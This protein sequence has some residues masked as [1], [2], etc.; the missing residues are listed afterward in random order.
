MTANVFT[1]ILS[2][3]VSRFREHTGKSTTTD[4]TDAN[5]EKWINDYYQNHFPEDADVDLL[6]GWHTQETSAVDDGEYSLI[7]TI[8]KLKKPVFLGRGGTETEIEL[9]QNR[10]LFFRMFPENEQYVTAPSLAIGSNDTTRLANSAFKYDIQGWTYTKAAAETA[11]SG[12]STVPQNK[13]GA[14]SLKIDSDGTVTIAEATDNS[15]G[16]ETAAK[17]INDLSKADSDSAYMGFVTVI[18]TDSGGFIPGTTALDDSAITDTYTD[19]QPGNRQAPQAVCVY[20]SYLY[21][22]P[23]PDDIYQIR[24]PKLLRP[25]ALDS[26]EAPLDIKWGSAIATG[27]ALLY[28][29]SVMKDEDRAAELKPLFDYFIEQIRGKDI[30]QMTERI[31]ER[32]F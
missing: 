16:Y 27:A 23:K 2:E 32:S 19:G 18:S 3:I 1:W 9:I 12:L 26:G 22:R 24:C 15:T 11:F 25:D 30:M 29:K 4:I 28:I 6:K 5:C 7:Q 21:A 31:I 10:E 13:Y 8:L 14:F 17:A 20:K